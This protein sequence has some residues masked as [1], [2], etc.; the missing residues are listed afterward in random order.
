VRVGSVYSFIQPTKCTIS[1]T[2]R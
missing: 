1:G 2:Y